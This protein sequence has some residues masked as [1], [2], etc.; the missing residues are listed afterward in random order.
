MKQQFIKFLNELKF[1]TILF[2]IAIA[3][4]IVMRV[5]LFTSI[6]KIPSPSM[7]P[8]ILAGDFII[9]N[10]LIPGPRVFRNLRH[11]ID[12]KIQTKRF[13][14]IRKVRRND[15]L[16][17]NFPYADK[18][19][20]ID[21]ALNVYYLKRCVAQPGDIF[22]IEN[23]KYTIENYPDSVG[24]IFRQQELS[25]MSQHDFSRGVWR[26]FPFDSV[27]YQW[28]IKNFGPLYVPKEGTT[29][30][31]DTMNVRLY[32]NLIEYETNKNLSVRNGIVYIGD[33]IINNY[34]FQ[35]NYY[36][37]AGDN[38]FDSQDSRYWGLLPEDCIIGKAAIVL[39][40]VDQQTGKFRWKRFFKT[41]K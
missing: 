9:A 30:A 38:I 13:K 32:K 35:M 17:F 24:Y 41:I 3:I 36:F 18:W 37:M 34:T 21:M 4:A 23:G 7:E 40:S 14:G 16:V 5:F 10:K 22:I 12:E 11:R 39:K 26:S 1:Y 20:K 29:I 27:H 6:I 31:I 28:N 15:I 25:Q 33:A 2:L 8:A 19:D